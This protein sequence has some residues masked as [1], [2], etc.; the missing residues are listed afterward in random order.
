MSFTYFSKKKVGGNTDFGKNLAFR[1]KF[2]QFPYRSSNI[3][4][5]KMFYSTISA[6][7]LRICRAKKSLE[8]FKTDTSL[9]LERMNIKDRH[10]STFRKYYS[11]MNQNNNNCFCF[12][13]GHFSKF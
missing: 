1:A 12:C 5:S 3:M 11:P 13:F 7:I 9:F 8:N 4:P 2:V 10:K 6:E